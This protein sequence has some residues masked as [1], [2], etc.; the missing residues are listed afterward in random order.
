MALIKAKIRG[1]K[2]IKS[3]GDSGADSKIISVTD[4]ETVSGDKN[5]F[6][7]PEL[8]SSTG[9]QAWNYDS[10]SPLT[11]AT[12]FYLSSTSDAGVALSNGVNVRVSGLAPGSHV[13]VVGLH[14][15]R[16]GYLSES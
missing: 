12:N 5:S 15:G 11:L 13:V 16:G 1:Q 7:L 10:G 14:K 4:L 2:F 3:P 8:V 6:I 9:I